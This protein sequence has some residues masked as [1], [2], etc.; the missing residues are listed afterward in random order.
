MTDDRT[1]HNLLTE[2]LKCHEVRLRYTRIRR[3]SSAP[4]SLTV[5]LVGDH[6]KRVH[7]RQSRGETQRADN[8][9]G[10][11]MATDDRTR[12]LREYVQHKPDCETRHKG[13]RW[14]PN[15]KRHGKWWFGAWVPDSTINPACTCG[16]DALLAAG[17]AER[18]T[19]SAE[20]E[21]EIAIAKAEV[22]ACMTQQ[23]DEQFIEDRM[24]CAYKLGA[25]TPAPG[26][27]PEQ[28]KALRYAI[29][30]VRDRIAVEAPKNALLV[31][32]FVVQLENLLFSRLPAP[33]AAAK[34]TSK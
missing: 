7:F 14:E 34:E 13:Q 20:L 1:R 2:L 5:R 32:G 33:L 25:E 4:Y 8:R 15:Y 31:A 9:K 30:I 29:A 24:R 21:R 28:E 11:V 19:P 22:H 18:P 26:W 17:E 3:K 10:D 16:L 27:L 23:H 6:W 12:R